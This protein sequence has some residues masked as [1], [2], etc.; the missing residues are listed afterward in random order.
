MNLSH[1]ER[2]FADFLSAMESKEQIFLHSGSKDCNG[3]PHTISLPD[4]LFIIGT[5]NIDETTYMFSPKVLDRANVIEFRVDEKEMITFLK[6]NTTV[7]FTNILSQGENM[8]CD[9]LTRAV[10]KYDSTKIQ[11]S[12]IEQ[13]LLFF[14]EL[15][16]VGAEFGYRTAAEILRFVAVT[17]ELNDEWTNEQILDAAIMQKLL[18]KLHGSR[19]KLEATLK[20]LTG[21]CLFDKALAADIL[22]PK[23]N[24]DFKDTIRIKY[25]L[26]LE[27]IRRMNNG[28][29]G[30]NFTSYAEA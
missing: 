5:V 14:R 23:K 2:Y 30:N 25:P 27:K 12:V 18:P 10:R 8:A 17:K 24:I 28:L 13:L 3:V 22:N 20:S 9:F 29:I 19:R 26:S 4:N 21:L 1:V 15:K 11:E 16:L 7:D 6:G